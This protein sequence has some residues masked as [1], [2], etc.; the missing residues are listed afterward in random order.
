MIASLVSKAKLLCLS[1][2]DPSPD[3]SDTRD[4]GLRENGVPNT[5]IVW[6]GASVGAGGGVL[7]EGSL[8]VE[9]CSVSNAR[10]G[11]ASATKVSSKM[12]GY[13]DSFGTV[14]CSTVALDEGDV[15]AEVKLAS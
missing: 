14:T 12:T 1:A 5:W 10:M 2:F 15:S 13:S 9:E 3:L 7:I 8:M 6:T 4:N 11:A